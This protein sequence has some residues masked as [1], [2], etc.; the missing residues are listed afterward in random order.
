MS[1]ETKIFLA[2]TND[3]LQLH[4]YLQMI[5]MEYLQNSNRIQMVNFFVCHVLSKEN[6]CRYVVGFLMKIRL[7]IHHEL[8]NYDEVNHLFE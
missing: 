3:F 4:R 7:L 8:G 1:K 6:L 5:L 2:K